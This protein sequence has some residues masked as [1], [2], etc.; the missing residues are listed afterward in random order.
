M[1]SS[2]IRN[3]SNHCSFRSSQN[4]F[5][6]PP[7]SSPNANAIVTPDLTGYDVAQ[8]NFMRMMMS[9]QARHGNAAGGMPPRA[10]KQRSGPA[11]EKVRMNKD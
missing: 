2:R 10:Y 8:Q 6:L 11:L 3:D 4:S 9:M 1:P 5:L 7:A